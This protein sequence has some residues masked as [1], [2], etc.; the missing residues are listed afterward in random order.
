MEE[1][2]KR[3]WHEMSEVERLKKEARY[4]FNTGLV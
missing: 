3:L 4:A 2:E 1:E